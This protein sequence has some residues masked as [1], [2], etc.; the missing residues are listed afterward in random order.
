MTSQLQI[1][2]TPLMTPSLERVFE[3]CFY[4]LLFIRVNHIRVKYHFS[5]FSYK[6]NLSAQM[7][8]LNDEDQHSNF[9]LHPFGRGY[10]YFVDLRTFPREPNSYSYALDE[11]N[12]FGSTFSQEDKIIREGLKV[13]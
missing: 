2:P 4:S 5:C 7:E 13:G 3:F 10:H 8:L 1:R 9:R 12:V 6:N 11:A